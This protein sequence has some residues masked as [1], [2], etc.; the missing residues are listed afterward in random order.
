M[1][2]W[3][4]R[5][6]TVFITQPLPKNTVKSNISHYIRGWLFSTSYRDNIKTDFNQMNDN[7]NEKGI[8]NALGF[9]V[10]PT[11][12]FSLKRQELNI[13]GKFL[14]FPIKFEHCSL[15]H[16]TQHDQTKATL[17]NLLHSRRSQ[18]I[19]TYGTENVR[20]RIANYWKLRAHQAEQAVR[21]GTLQSTTYVV[22]WKINDK[23][24]WK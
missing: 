11:I 24:N 1:L 5:T 4:F 23:Q 16:L 20:D 18:S 12:W 21:Y 14:L 10:K 2:F 17:W 6:L 3:F 9:P 13:K 8:Q 7:L 15:R 19:P 22:I